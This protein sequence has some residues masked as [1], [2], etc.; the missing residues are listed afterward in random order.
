MV[1]TF[2]LCDWI[3]IFIKKWDF[4]LKCVLV[5]YIYVQKSMQVI[6]WKKK[7]IEFKIL[8]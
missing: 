5:V 1:L 6:F 7:E 3:P 4:S 2:V 8:K